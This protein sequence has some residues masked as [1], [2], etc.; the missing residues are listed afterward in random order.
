MSSITLKTALAALLLAPVLA[1]AATTTTNTATFSDSA[2]KDLTLDGKG[3]AIIDVSWTDPVSQGSHTNQ[4]FQASSLV[5]NL[6]KGDASKS[7]GS[8][9]FSDVIGDTNSGKIVINESGLAKGDYTLKFTG[10]WV[11]PTGKEGDWNGSVEEKVS[12]GKIQFSNVSPVPEPETYAMLLV[13]LGVMGA[14]AVRR[15]KSNAS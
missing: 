6:Y 10:N 8:G 15:R 7:I 4:E 9:S 3:F 13:G 14:I 1:L 5:W 11:L 2:D 12:L